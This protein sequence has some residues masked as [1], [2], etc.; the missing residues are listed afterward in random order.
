MRFDGHPI[1]V[2]KLQEIYTLLQ[3][4]AIHLWEN[5]ILLG[6]KLHAMYGVLSDNLSS[7]KPGYCF[8]DDDHNPFK[9]QMNDL[10]NA[11]F[12]NPQLF[13]LFMTK[14][15]SG[16][17]VLNQ[18]QIKKWLQSLAE[19]ELYTLLGAEMKSGA[20]IRMTELVSTLMRNRN[21]RIRNVMGVGH[22]LALIRQYTKNSNNQQMDKM[23]P[24]GFSGFEQDLIIQIHTFARPLA[25]VSHFHK[26]NL[27]LLDFMH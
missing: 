26:V 6:L 22:Y 12:S 3:N 9:S 20:P 14:D 15:A 18:H 16:N 19:L 5:K 7:T 4:K 21:T 8:L 27:S 2:Q 1:S 13:Q 24:H 17:W 25:I 11:I 10:G 23:I